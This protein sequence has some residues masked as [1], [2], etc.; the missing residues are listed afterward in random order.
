MKKNF[1]L[2]ILSVSFVFLFF[3]S[4]GDVA[5]RARISF[6]DVGQGDAALFVSDNQEKIL[7][8]L[9]FIGL[10]HQP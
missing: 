10:M 5:G 7:Q 6:F 4:R 9:E 1:I 8:T 3:L 2:L